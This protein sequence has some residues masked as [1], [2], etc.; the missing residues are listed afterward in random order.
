M[1]SKCTVW[2]AKK[3][4]SAVL[5]QLVGF[6]AEQWENGNTGAVL[7]AGVREAVIKGS[8]GE[9]VQCESVRD[10]LTFWQD[11]A[12]QW[13]GTRSDHSASLSLVTVG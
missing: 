6:E 10:S 4:R 11:S 5:P 13:K 3:L 7:D 1:F 12:T 9:S 8:M 2:K